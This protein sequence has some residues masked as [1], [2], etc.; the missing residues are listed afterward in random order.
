MYKLRISDNMKMLHNGYF[1]HVVIRRNL[2]RKSRY[3][4]DKNKNA[5]DK[6]VKFITEYGDSLAKGDLDELYNIAIKYDR[7]LNDLSKG[8]SKKSLKALTYKLLGYDDFVQATFGLNLK[9]KFCQDYGL[10]AYSSKFCHYAQEWIDQNIKINFRMPENLHV[11]QFEKILNG[12]VYNYLFSLGFQNIDSR[13]WEFWT[14][15][16]YTSMLGIKVCPYCN[17]QFISTVI[18]ED[19]K[20]RG[21]IDHFFPKGKYPILSMSIYNW[22]PCCSVCNSSFKKDKSF[23]FHDLNPYRDDI[24]DHFQYGIE[25]HGNEFRVGIVESDDKVEK[26]LDVFGLR[27]LASLHDDIGKAMY[28]KRICYSEKYL[29]DLC[30][31]VMNLYKTKEELKCA[32][33]DVPLNKKQADQECLGKLRFDIAKQLHWKDDE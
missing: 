15:Y 30:H 20:V 23:D 11:G 22:V 7:L 4:T 25:N 9:L 21:N 24:G 2:A 26:Y 18:K 12:E 19:G 3:Y 1:Q 13:L 10:A 5:V 31:G 8:A 27:E 32:L 14:P 28:Q 17:R 6:I 33:L 29:N 16:T